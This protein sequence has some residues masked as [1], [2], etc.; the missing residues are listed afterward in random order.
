[1]DRGESG[2]VGVN[3]CKQRRRRRE[4]VSCFLII[5]GATDATGVDHECSTS[6]SG[7]VL[8]VHLLGEFTGTLHVT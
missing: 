2:G 8:W 7:G 6:P 5:R 3:F 4:E 1:M